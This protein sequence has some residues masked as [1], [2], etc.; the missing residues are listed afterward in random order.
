MTA[1]HGKAKHILSLDPDTM[2]IAVVRA[3][4]A[5]PDN[6][7]WVR[8]HVAVFWG[9]GRTIVT[10]LGDPQA[11]ARTLKM[12]S[13]TAAFNLHSAF[14]PEPHGLFAVLDES[15]HRF[16]GDRWTA[17]DGTTDVP[18]VTVVRATLNGAYM[19]PL[20]GALG[21]WK[22]L[23]EGS[24][25]RATIAVSG[26]RVLVSGHGAS[27]RVVIGLDGSDP[28]PVAVGNWCAVGHA[29]G[30]FAWND[31][32]VLDIGLDGGVRDTEITK[33]AEAADRCLFRAGDAIY[34]I[35]RSTVHRYRDGAWTRHDM[36]AAGAALGLG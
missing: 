4:T 26:S 10:P 1:V 8:D 7:F 17:I 34:F 32:K 11:K 19:R 13:D 14:V 3:F 33:N 23:V 15:V 20:G 12:P 9:L 6:L 36:A 24:A 2:Q 18:D 30:F 16:D 29:S 31:H 22:T 25:T 28:C 35:Q 21:A 5:P 27:R